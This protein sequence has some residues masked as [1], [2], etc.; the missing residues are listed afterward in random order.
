MTAIIELNGVSKSFGGIR[1]LRDV[2]FTID[3]GEIVGL[4]GP[5]G[6]GKTTLVNVMTGVTGA[7]AG[8]VIFC[9][10]NVTAQRPYQAARRGIARTFQVVQPF[11]RMTVLENV[12]AGALFGGADREVNVRRAADI[13]R[14]QLEFTELAAL[15]DKPAG[16][17]TIAG[18]KRLE[19][20]K[21]LAMQ[22]KL[23]MLDE[24]NAGLNSTEIDRALALVRKISERGV[25]ILLIEHLMKVILSLAQRVLVLH[26]GELVAQGDPVAM[27]NDRR[28]IEAYLGE[29]FARRYQEGATGA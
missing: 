16:S 24:V 25:T 14:E 7:T 8:Q 27:V 9:G 5:N 2:S 21:S 20:A 12:M 28:V 17:L 6:A 13:A 26:Q 11:P 4:I 29:K 15:A 19:L 10:A 23:L 18:R 3:Q 1:A 22:P